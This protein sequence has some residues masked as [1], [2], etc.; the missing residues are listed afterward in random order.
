MWL[1][2]QI[3][4]QN[5]SIFLLAV[6][7]NPIDFGGMIENGEPGL[8]FN[9]LIGF[10]I[11]AAFQRRLLMAFDADEDVGVFLRRQREDV[12]FFDIDF[13]FRDAVF[14]EGIQGAIDRRKIEPFFLQLLLHR[15]RSHGVSGG[16]KNAKHG[17]A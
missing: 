11:R 3:S 7:T 10:V 4:Q 17:E 12:F 14:D 8:L 15:F 9:R 6:G 13:F 1:I 16:R 5:L 2:F